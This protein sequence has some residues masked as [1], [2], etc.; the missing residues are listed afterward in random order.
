[1]EDED[2]RAVRTHAAE[3]CMRR[4]IHTALKT[5]IAKDIFK[6]GIHFKQITPQRGKQDEVES[7]TPARLPT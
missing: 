1:M 7:C 3:S 6:A 5:E 4:D 2:K